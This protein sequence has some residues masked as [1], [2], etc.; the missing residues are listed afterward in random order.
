MKEKKADEFH[1][2]AYCTNCN[3]SGSVWRG[4]T[5]FLDFT[6]CPRCG[7]SVDNFRVHTVR[8]VQIKNPNHKWWNL[9]G[10]WLPGYW[11]DKEGN[12]V[13]YKNGKRVQYIGGEL[14]T[15]K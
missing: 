4:S 5:F 3:A 2:R 1:T 12:R 13:G 10:K 7:N 9:F 6:V 11:E 14:I 8:Y 15:E